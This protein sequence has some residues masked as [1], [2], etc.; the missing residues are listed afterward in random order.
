V[1][2]DAVVL[3]NIDATMTGLSLLLLL[4][5]VRAFSFCS[6]LISSLASIPLTMPLITQAAR[7]QSREPFTG[8]DDDECENAVVPVE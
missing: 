1:S 2:T 3:P 7:N 5:V 8:D 4:L 6:C